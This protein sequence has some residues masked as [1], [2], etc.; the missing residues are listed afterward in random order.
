VCPKAPPPPGRFAPE[1]AAGD[2]LSLDGLFGDG[3]ET[4]EPEPRK[5]RSR[6]SWLL[7]RVFRAELETCCRCGGP[8]R[9]VEVATEQGA[10]A[11]LL[12]KHGL[13]LGRLA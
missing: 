5:G 8:M 10:I 9:W 13:Y 4:T 6:W 1:P 2:Q 11:R 12:A 7:K 3:K